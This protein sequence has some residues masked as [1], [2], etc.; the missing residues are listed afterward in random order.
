MRRRSRNAGCLLAML[1]GVSLAR[2]AP[3]AAQFPPDSFINLRVLPADIPSGELVAMMAGFTRALGV[4]CSYCHVGE[5]SRPLETYDFA[6]D[7]KAAKR[8]AR[9]MIEM[10]GRINGEHLGQLESRAEPALR[11]ECVTCHRGA[12]EPRMLQD[13]L[14][15]AYDAGGADSVIATYN[16]LRARRYG[17]F[18]FDFGEVPLADVAGVIGRRPG[19]LI[20]AE[21]LHAL[22]V[23]MNPTSAFAKRSHAAALAALRGTDSR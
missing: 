7:D 17:G 2:T 8:K 21:R 6:A 9:T 15:A 12:R 1:A 5:E 23:E 4:R 13:I 10:L 22:N 19:G 20:D 14:I 3:L 11:V 18:T 16:D